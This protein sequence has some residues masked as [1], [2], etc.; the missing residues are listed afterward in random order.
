MTD[1]IAAILVFICHQAAN[2][3]SKA[4]KWRIRTEIFENL[5]VLQLPKWGFFEF[6]YPFGNTSSRKCCLSIKKA[7]HQWLLG[8]LPP[9]IM[10]PSNKNTNTKQTLNQ[11]QTATGG[12]KNEEDHQED[13]I[14]EGFI[15]RRNYLRN[16][17]HLHPRRSNSFQ[18]HPHLQKRNRC[19][20]RNLIT[21]SQKQLYIITLPPDRPGLQIPGRFLC[22]VINGSS[23]RKHI[24]FGKARYH[25]GYWRAIWKDGWKRIKTGYRWKMVFCVSHL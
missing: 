1:K 8:P 2:G 14:K 21:K 5:S 25:F 19:F 15:S 10:K 22:L 12:K 20:R 16:R 13:R 18:L 23:T 7:L 24:R 4:R 11:K 9:D 6:S 17:N 3:V